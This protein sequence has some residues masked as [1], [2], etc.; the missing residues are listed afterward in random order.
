[1]RA[2]LFPP[3]DQQIGGNIQTEM[4]VCIGESD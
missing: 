3:D 1:V 2:L 4:Q